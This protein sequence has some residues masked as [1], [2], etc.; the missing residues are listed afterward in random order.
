MNLLEILRQVP[1]PRLE[2]RK[3]H[4]LEIVLGIALCAVLSGAEDFEDMANYGCDKQSFLETMFEMPNGIPSHDTFNRVFK[5]LKPDAFQEVLFSFTRQLVAA[6]QDKQICIDGK[7]IRSTSISGKK[8]NTCQTILSAWVAENCAV[9]NM[10]CVDEKSNEITAVPELLACLDIKGSKVSMDAMGCQ[11]EIAGLIA[12]A[13]AD[14]LL[15]VKGNQ[16]TL[17]MEVQKTFADTDKSA[18][19]DTDRDFDYGHGRIETRICQLTEDLSQIHVAENWKDLKSLIKISTIRECKKTGKVEK[20]ERYYISN[21][22]WTAKQANEAVRKHW[23][24]ENKLHWQLDV[25]FGEDNQCA[26]D[27]IVTQNLNI[28]YK[29]SL[30]ILEQ[31]NTKKLSKKS[32]RK[33]AAWNDQFLSLIHISEP[34]R[35]Y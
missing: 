8:G 7:G 34:T 31:S 28:L 18:N 23:G 6:L 12:D 17:E 24:I 9:I 4:R 33:K 16:P 32:K 13:G 29:L 1:D 5:M 21:G 25:T 27:R 10:V 19:F 2:R 15:A 14:Y 11:R 30:Q 3:L 20:Q 35:P 22:K 26:S